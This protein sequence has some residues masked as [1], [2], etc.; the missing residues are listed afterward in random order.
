MQGKMRELTTDELKGVSGGCVGGF[1]QCLAVQIVQVRWGS[2][3]IQSG[4][5]NIANPP[6]PPPPS[7][8][9]N[10]DDNSGY[11]SFF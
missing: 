3:Q 5:N 6:P 10:D 11:C 9:S 2:M 4:V 7:C 1:G 8:T